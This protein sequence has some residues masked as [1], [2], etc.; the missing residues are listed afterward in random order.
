M[1]Q[2]PSRIRDLIAPVITGLGYEAVGIEYHSGDSDG[3]LRIYIDKP[4]GITVEDCQLISHQV[5]GVL[6][7]E[8]PISE[9]YHLEVSSP[10]MDRPL[11]CE[12]DFDRFT[13]QRAKLKLA[14]KRDG[15]MRYSGLLCGTED[16]CVIIDVDGEQFRLPFDEI[17]TARLI[18]NL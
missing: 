3:V 9:S 6:D 15:R 4:G 18:P 2:A 14:V 12:A 11:Y 7:V 17:D 16:G 5:S 8:D 10:G 1:R 13:G